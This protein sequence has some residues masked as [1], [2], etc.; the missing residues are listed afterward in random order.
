M[1]DGPTGE[2]GAQHRTPTRRAG[3]LGSPIQHSLS[4]LLHRAAYEGLGLDWAYD[5]YEV[6]EAGLPGF[7]AGLDSTWAGLSLTMPL[8]EAALRVAVEVDGRARAVRAVNTLLPVAG[9]WRGVNTDITGMVR[10]LEGAGLAAGPSTATVL[11]AG[12]TARSAIAAL[13]DLGVEQVTVV[14]RRPGAAD[15]VAELARELGIRA[16]VAGP[17]PNRALL[18]ADVVVST[19][20]GDAAAD[21]A[22]LAASMAASSAGALLDASYHPW[23]TALA[24][25]WGSGVVASGRDMLLWQAVE[26]VRLMTGLVP[27]AGRMAA[28]L[29]D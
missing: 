27:D 5:A 23:P 4:P 28:A 7:V 17:D 14:A 2:G 11:G 9:G 16:G 29:P 10:A 1:S 19:L 22:P 6:D 21:W 12:A 18:T 13:V 15:G 25:A 3:V 8:K 26:Q 24:A 20:P